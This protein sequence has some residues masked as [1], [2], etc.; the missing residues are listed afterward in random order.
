MHIQMEG[1]AGNT[2]PKPDELLIP[3]ALG[4]V[5]AVFYYKN[6]QEKNRLAAVIGFAAF[7]L[8]L[9]LTAESVN[10]KKSPV[11]KPD[12]LCL[13]DV[14]DYLPNVPSCSCLM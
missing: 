3:P 8:P 10:Y 1:S 5:V 14:L 13:D 4:T 9:F 7:R 12:F 11:L 6:G 2:M